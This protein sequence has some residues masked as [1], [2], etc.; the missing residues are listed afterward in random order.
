MQALLH[1]SHWPTLTIP[2]SSPTRLLQCGRF[3]PLDSFDGEMRSCRRQLARHA[4]RRRAARAAAAA[5][6]SAATSS[7]SSSHARDGGAEPLGPSPTWAAPASPLPADPAAA[8]VTAPPQQLSADAAA[9]HQAQAGACDQ[10]QAQALP[11]VQASGSDSGSSSLGCPS[12]EQRSSPSPGLDALLAAAEEEEAAEQEAA[13]ERR[14]AS[15]RR[16]AQPAEQEQEA[17]RALKRQA[18][19]GP[20]ED[21]FA[22]P[23]LAAWAA[24]SKP[25]TPTPDAAAM[26]YLSQ[27]ASLPEMM[28]PPLA[29][30][31]LPP[32]ALPPL[33]APPP[34]ALPPQV[35]AAAASLGASLQL[36]QQLPM[37]AGLAGLPAPAGWHEACVAGMAGMAAERIMIELLSA[38][39]Q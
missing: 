16:L 13:V 27:Q 28:L 21:W 10:P 37:Q 2:C 15:K 6:R 1:T 4:E 24:P 23:L 12:G 29:P 5:A 33:A 32:L 20:P 11:Q 18:S 31:T 8:A 34:P 19:T 17:K 26:S 3:H 35:A 30:L 9:F 7:P 14:A 36:L 39:R 25:A 22:P 38:I